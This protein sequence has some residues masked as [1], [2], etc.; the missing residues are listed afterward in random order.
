[1]K[2]KIY[3][4]SIIREII[5]SK[6]RFISILAI[7]LL[8]VSFYSGIKS[9]GP[10]MQNTINEFYNKYNLMDSK[11]VSSLGLTDKD[12]DLVKDNDKILDYYATHSIDANLTNF[13]SVVK[14]LEYNNAIENPINKFIIVK[15]NL[16]KNSGEIALD[17]Q[18]LKINKNLKIGDKYTI[19]SDEDVMK[20]FRKTTFKIVGFVKSPMY[21][22]K[23]SRGLTSI[24][25]GNVDYF[26][27]L[28]KLD[29]NMDVYTEI[30][31]KFKNVEGIDAYSDE[32]EDIMQKNNKYL[33][34]LYSNREKERIS[35]VKLDIKKKFNKSYENAKYIDVNT[36]QKQESIQEEKLKKLDSSQY[37]FLNRNDNPGYT[38]YKDL[39][40]SLD[41]IALVFPVFFFLVAVLICLTTLT[42]MVEENRMEIGTLK[43]LG[44]SNLEIA[45]K[46]IVYS[47]IASILGSILGIL[48]GCNL[49]PYVISNACG[50]L[51]NLPKLNIYYYSSYIIQS[52]LVSILCTVGASIFVLN[53]E[54]KSNP[55]SLMRGKSPKL[56]KKIILER[57]TILWNRLSFNQ[58]VTLRN[59]FR[60]KQR[61]IM[62]VL[63][64]AGCMA[65]L[66]TGF[67]L[68]DSN[69]AVL[70]KQFNKLW[71][72]Q[73]M[74]VFDETYKGKDDNEYNE[75]LKELK[76]YKDSLDIHQEIVTFSKKG[77]NKQTATM[78]LPK[79]LESLNKFILLN[80]RT[81]G[82][83]YKLSDD[84]VIITEKLAK[85]LGASAGDN[86]I[87]KDYDNNSY[88]VKVSN[89]VE[90]Y[91]SHFIYISPSY[92]EKIYNEKPVYNSQLLKLNQNKESED[93]STKLM[94]VDK[95]M[96]VTLT[97]K[98][99]ESSENSAGNLN[100]VMLVIIIS[101]GSL[102]FVV[103]YNLTNINISERIREL[104]TIKVLGFFD[105]E[106]TMYILR[107][108]IIL[109]L[110]G[111][112]TGSFMGKMLYFFIINTSETDNMMMLPQVYMNSYILS[113]L[114]TIVF[115]LFV[116]IM[117][118]V[119]LK[120]INMIDALKSID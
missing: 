69:S 50:S 111:I 79:N 39:I 97:S 87:M 60:Y 17:E 13:N 22:E 45:K 16:P 19:E 78:Y 75:L 55:T 73:A 91:F 64:I 38:S 92:Y 68:R 59:I 63:G 117:M 54:L 48:L 100:A 61:M 120:N 99:K 8:G 5:S 41:S 15:G 65:M 77:M 96:N 21:I 34:N 84:G 105:N 4:K 76:G 6:A 110:L 36:L 82:K 47:S 37:Y 46:F 51:F 31:L 23:E 10:D 58:K 103:L 43:A 3:D 81:S 88:E 26:A 119:K 106:V 53:S 74:V 9:S 115:S 109:T 42:R 98:L 94:S 56:G 108:N 18:A 52:I 80:D 28:N 62:T 93:I 1:M 101:S 118:H 66:V 104:S 112:F 2:N 116:M 90:N 30:Y 29:I 35:E 25:K 27:V 83:K 89:I 44:Y 114:I 20:S 7:I 72:Y 67:A 113:G 24:G 107:E 85:L 70:D 57:I 95:V 33:E 102:A 49:F 40:K 32:Y 71:N 11:I 86:I 14:F 12:L